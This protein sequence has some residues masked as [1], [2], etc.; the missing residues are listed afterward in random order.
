MNDIHGKYGIL[1]SN[2]E[3][4]V[5]LACALANEIYVDLRRS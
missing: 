3:A 1:C 2:N 5:N 4:D